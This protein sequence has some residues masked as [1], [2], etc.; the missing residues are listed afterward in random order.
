MSSAAAKAANAGA[1]GQEDD[2]HNSRCDP[3]LRRLD[4]VEPVVERELDVALDVL[5]PRVVVA[6]PSV[7]AA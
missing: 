4:A 3:R 1:E 2:D 6:E 7:R 5:Q